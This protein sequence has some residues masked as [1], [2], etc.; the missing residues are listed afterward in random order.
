M[1]NANFEIIKHMHRFPSEEGRLWHKEL[2]FVSWNGRMPKYDIRYWTD[3]NTQPGRG[4]ALTET[5]FRELIEAAES[6]LY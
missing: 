4:I 3:R 6:I 1:G 2:N 5:E